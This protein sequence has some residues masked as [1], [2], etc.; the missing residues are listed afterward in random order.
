MSE[1]DFVLQSIGFVLLVAEFELSF[2]PRLTDPITG[3][4]QAL[5]RYRCARQPVLAV[6]VIIDQGPN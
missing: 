1:Q 4:D 2:R 5:F 6:A 3:F